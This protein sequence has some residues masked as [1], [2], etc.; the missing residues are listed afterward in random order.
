MTET[1]LRTYFFG[2]PSKMTICDRATYDVAIFLMGEHLVEYWKTNIKL[3]FRRSK[4]NYFTKS[5]EFKLTTPTKGK[6]VLVDA[7]DRPRVRQ[8]GFGFLQLKDV[9]KKTRRKDGMNT[10]VH[11]AK[12]LIKGC[13]AR[14]GQHYNI[15]T[16]NMQE[17]GEWKGFPASY[18]M[19]WDKAFLKQ[20]E[21]ESS[22]MAD[23]IYMVKGKTQFKDKGG[24]VKF[25]TAN[26]V[27]DAFVNGQIKSIKEVMH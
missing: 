22:K 16:G 14:Q 9:V 12:I 27:F 6:S 25:N 2:D 19:L 7:L 15:A 1:F 10:S 18:W 17:G 26:E 5:G 13:P 23:Y 24:N 8:N 11:L 21:K 20:C 4:P 3:Y